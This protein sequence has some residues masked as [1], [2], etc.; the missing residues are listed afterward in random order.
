MLYKLVLLTLGLASVDEKCPQKRRLCSALSGD[1]I[2]DCPLPQTKVKTIVW[3]AK[4][5]I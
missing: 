5:K 2:C 3:K 1:G 4:N